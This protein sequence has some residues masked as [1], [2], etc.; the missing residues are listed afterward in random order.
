MPDAYLTMHSYGKIVLFP[1]TYAKNAESPDN[2]DELMQL[3]AEI[4]SK[5]NP[6]WI[7]GQGKICNNQFVII[8]FRIYLPKNESCKKSFRG[9]VSNAYFCQI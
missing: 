8:T 1:Y 6:G 2:Y 5:M 9:R 4:T 7:F 3:S